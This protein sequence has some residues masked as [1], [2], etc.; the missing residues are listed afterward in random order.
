M[1]I[2]KLFF[3]LL[4]RAW[5]YVLVLVPIIIMFPFLIVL[6]IGETTYNYF[7]RLAR[8]WA[9]FILF[10]MAMPYRRDG[11][12]KIIPNRSY[13]FVA[14]H[15]SMIDIMMMLAVVKR[16]FV[17]VGKKELASIPVFGFFY[18]RTCILVDRN[19]PASRKN[20]FDEANRRIEAG[21]SICIFPEGKVPD[22]QSV[23]L[24]EFKDG[25]FRLAIEHQIPIVPIVFPDN[26]RHFSYDFFSGSPGLLRAIFLNPISTKQLNATHRKELRMQ[27]REKMLLHL[28]N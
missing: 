15:T 1:K 14:N 5:F 3:V 28:K 17:F 9:K 12:V 27:V 11:G 4:Y 26:K 13:M 8:V 2:I 6:T 24:D 20:A 16:P 23:V 10:G 7:F 18:K 19:S 25:A 22:D 21:T